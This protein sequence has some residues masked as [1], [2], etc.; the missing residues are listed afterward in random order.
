MRARRGECQHFMPTRSLKTK[1]SLA[2]LLPSVALFVLIGSLS[3]YW[4]AH[5]LG[6]QL[7]E[8]QAATARLYA[9]LL[10]TSVWQVDR[11]TL[12]GIAEQMSGIADLVTF[13]VADEAGSTLASY[14]AVNSVNSSDHNVRVEPI[15]ATGSD[16]H[17]ERVGTLRVVFSST[18]IQRFI[19]DEMIWALVA[20]L[21]LLGTQIAGL[22]L[23][24][25]VIIRRPL[26]ALVDAIRS[27]DSAKPAGLVPMSTNDELGVVIDAFNQMQR[28]LEAHADRLRLVYD[29]SPGLLFYLD[30]TGNFMAV[31]GFFAEALGYAPNELVGRSLADLVLDLTPEQFERSLASS[32]RGGLALKSQHLK[33]RTKLPN[34]FVH[35]LI[36][37]IPEVNVDG[38]L[39]GSFCVMTDISKQ[40]EAQDVMLHQASHDQMTEL[41]NRYLLI[42]RIREGIAQSHAEGALLALVF[43]DIDRFKWVNDSFGHAFGDQLLQQVASRIQHV[44]RRGDTAAR[45][46]G[47]EFVVVLPRVDD[48]T[49]INQVV[50]RLMADLVLPYQIDNEQIMCT[51]SVGIACFPG[52]GQTAEQ[53]LMQADMAMYQ[54]KE[55]GRNTHRFYSPDMDA[56]AK[57]RIQLASEVALA[58]EENRLRLN[59]QPLIDVDSGLVVGYEA[60]VR[61]VSAHDGHVVM[62]NAFIPVAEDRGYIHEI[63]MW[64]VEQVVPLLAHWP[65]HDPAWPAPGHISVNVSP[66]QLRDPAFVGRVRDVLKRHG[67]AAERLALE[68]TESCLVDADEANMRAL[69]GLSALGC[70]LAIDD[71]GTGFS[72]LASLKQFPFSVLKIDR[73]FVSGLTRESS[74]F[75]LIKTIVDIA[76]AFN[77]KLI[78]EGIETGEELAVLTTILPKGR[79]ALAQGYLFGRPAALP[80]PEALREPKAAQPVGEAP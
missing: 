78:A 8:E 27:A 29:K 44:V 42:E 62:P 43:I 22:M 52:D 69:H 6:K 40:V 19:H 7:V 32:L 61:M 36:N 24:F 72:S 64:V 14:Q 57:S 79:M 55:E 3:G 12:R 17:V 48:L 59:F 56:R 77:M 9:R 15:T 41:P 58:R 30:A 38:H 63:G 80:M 20:G 66:I 73:S 39:E 67:V 13:D 71:F 50:T 45:F 47:D 51:T 23:A 1:L 35:T 49:T 54:G 70:P 26:D 65:L 5:Q 76:G 16:G 21:I 53:L 18:S 75:D 37:T 33:V 60:L 11:E 10:A 4:R 74:A 34:G 68:I 31:S 28:R 2:V 46:G 25:R